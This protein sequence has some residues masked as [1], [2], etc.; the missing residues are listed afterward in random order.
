MACVAGST[1]TE[2][3]YGA[4][5]EVTRPRFRLR[6]LLCCLVQGSLLPPLNKDNMVGLMRTKLP[7]PEPQGNTPMERLDWAFR[8]VLKVPKATVKDGE[9]AKHSRRKKEQKAKEQ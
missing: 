4:D 1:G 7:I 3:R 8:T 9:R 2:S 5:E 6:Q